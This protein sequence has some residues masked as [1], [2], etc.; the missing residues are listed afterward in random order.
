MIYSLLLNYIVKSP[1]GS[2]GKNY[3]I[4]GFVGSESVI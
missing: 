3:F 4:F 1:Y 2:F